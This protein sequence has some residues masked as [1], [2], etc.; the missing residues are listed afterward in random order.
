[1]TAAVQGGMAAISALLD[2]RTWDNTRCVYVV[3]MANGRVV[4]RVGYD[5]DD[6][7]IL[8]MAKWTRESLGPTFAILRRENS[9]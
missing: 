5:R 6:P 7:G 3:A 1:M 4:E 9:D 2:Q 8:A